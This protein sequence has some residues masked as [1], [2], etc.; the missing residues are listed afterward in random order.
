MSDDEKLLD[1][2]KRATA[3]LRDT[4]RRLRE[5]E[6]KEHEPIAVVGMSCRLPG[7]VKS[8]DDLWQLTADERDAISG[9]PANRGWHTDELDTATLQGGF[10]YDAPEFDADFFGISPREALAMD[11]QQRMLLETAWEAFEHAGID[12]TS[13]RATPVGV[14]TGVN[15]HGYASDVGELPE[16]VGGYLSTGVSGSVASGRVAYFMGLEGP[17]VTLDT[18]CSS[19]LVAVH[20]A[21]QALR[22]GDCTMALAGGVTVM[23]TPGA[24]VE[25][26]KQ[27][28]LSGDGRSKS[29]AAAADGTGWGEG[30]TT[31]LIEKLSDARKRGHQVL[32]VIRGTAVNQ[33]G[34]TNGLTAPSGK[35]QQRVIRAA[36]ADARLRPQ[37]VDAVEAHGTGT[38][39]G[40]PI[41]AQ[42]LL[43]TY[44]QDREV[45]LYLGSLKSNIGHT[46]AAAGAG[47]II[48]MVQALRYGVLPKSLHIDAPSPHI[49]W[50][51]GSVELLTEARAWPETGRPRR[52]GVS[53]FGMSGTNAHVVLEQAPAEEP[54]AEDTPAERP[55]GTLVP[56]TLSARTDAALRGQAE[57]LLAHLDRHPDA[58]PA[59]VARSLAAGRAHLEH[60][61][62]LIAADREEFALRLKE[63]AL[64]EPAPGVVRN[65]VT[66]DRSGP[67]FV[68]PGQGSQW[69]GMA[70]ELLDADPVFGARMAEC[71]R[72][73]SVHVDWS[74][75][76][77][78]RGEP[79]APGFDRVDVVQPV[80]FAVMVSLAALWRSYGVE[81]AAVVGHSQGE[82]A[83]A[84]VAG[85]LSLEDAAL[86]VALRSQAIREIA[87]HGGMMSVPQ[88]VAEVEERIAGYA[89]VSVAAVNGPRSTV[90]AGGALALDELLAAYEADGVRARRV[91]VDYASHSPHVEAIEERLAELLAPVRPLTPSVPF[92]TS[93]DGEIR[94]AFDAGYWYRNLR[95]TVRFERTLRELLADGHRRFVEIS[96]HPVLLPGVQETIETAGTHGAF[97]GETL[98]RH[99]GG[100][101]KFLSSVAEL[102]VRG[103]SV[104]WMAAAPTDGA[105][106]VPLPTY[107][108]QRQ[109]FWLESGIGSGD[110]AAAGLSAVG[111]PLAAA[112]VGLPGSGDLLFT[113]RLSLRSHP[114]AADR[115][116]HGVPAPG[117][118]V[119]AELA[120]GVG[121]RGGVPHLAELALHAPLLVPGQGAAQLRLVLSEGD[122]DGDGAR[123]FTVHSRAEDAPDG[124]DWTLH[125]TGTLT[126]AR[127]EAEQPAPPAVWPPRDAEPVD[128]ETVYGLLA[129][130][131]LGHGP[132]F[133]LL[134]EV[135]RHGD[136]LYAQTTLPDGQHDAD[137]GFALHPALLDAALQPLLADLADLAEDSDGLLLPSAWTAL[138]LHATGAKVLR[139]RVART[140]AHAAT[141]TSVD[142]AGHP[143]LTGTVHLAPVDPTAYVSRLPL[144]DALFG[145]E[146]HE[147]ESAEAV[148]EE[149]DGDW[150]VIG[151]PSLPSGGR[152]PDLTA[153]SDA[154][155]AGV[156]VPSY[157]RVDL[158]APGE[159]TATAVTGVRALLDAWSSDA[160]LSDSSLVL[161]SRGGERVVE[162]DEVPDLAV[163]AVRGLVRAW[164][165]AHPGRATLL[166][167]DGARDGA[168]DGATDGD[169]YGGDP[170]GVLAAAV[171]TGEPDL[172]LRAG[173]LRVRRLVRQ[174]AT[175]F[176][177]STGDLTAAGTILL[178][179]AAGDP[180]TAVL[181]HHLT[182][183]RG[184]R[185][186]T[187]AVPRH[188]V[189]ELQAEL[190]RLGADARVCAADLTDR[191]ATTELCASP[192]AGHPLTGVVH[193]AGG[194]THPDLAAELAAARH[195]DEAARSTDTAVFLL[196]P[197]AGDLLGAGQD[198][199][200]A[201]LAAHLDALAA[202]RRAAG[203][204]AAVLGWSPTAEAFG[205]LRPASPTEALRLLDATADTARTVAFVRPDP[206]AVREPGTAVPALLRSLVRPGARR[207]VN[208]AP[209]GSDALRA[210]LA[211]LTPAERES[212]LLPLVRATTA[213]VLGHASPDAVDPDRSFVELGIE[214]ITA[215]QLR[216]R[217]NEATALA[218][219]V[220]LVFDHPTATLLARHLAESLA[221]G[222]QV[223]GPQ[224][225]AT[226]G[227]LVRLFRQGCEL[228]RPTEA[229][230]L[231]TAAARL[232]P[233]FAMPEGISRRPSPVR[234]ARGTS[235]PAVYC[236]PSLSAISGPHEYLRFAAALQGVCDVTVLPHPGY[237]DG[238]QLPADRKALARA[239]AEAL[240]EESG[241]APVVLLGRSSGG[242]IAHQVAQELE[243]MGRPA[244][245]VI[246]LDTYSRS[247]DR[248]SLPLMTSQ[249]LVNADDLFVPLDDR[250]LTAMGRYIGIHSDWRPTAHDT[251][252]LLLRAA[253][254][255]PGV[256]AD[257]SAPEGGRPGWE[258]T[259]YRIEVPGDHFSMLDAHAATT[260][261][262]V[263]A[264]LGQTRP[265][266]DRA[267]APASA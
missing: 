240:L 171:A 176:T 152:Y 187:V 46:M 219:P 77:V 36:L 164:Q 102:Y 7:E 65:V 206:A 31:L 181:A 200:T 177:E 141:V 74:L 79:G 144:P 151:L 252:S 247:A 111:H 231:L 256:P 198:M 29:F 166:D 266:T 127:P 57:R 236:F 5:A 155:H 267:T 61:A 153:L 114:W 9:F 137:G 146:W 10:L 135:W 109:H 76:A 223:P 172:A 180:R 244:A 205:G 16:G 94:P 82:I 186:L 193:L 34:T 216:T 124:T 97:A 167:T 211:G 139:T 201:A 26:S 215:T 263:T 148:K 17:A 28:A 33:D 20:L 45:P 132:A 212:E 99:H 189:A 243:E 110:V 210:R 126:G 182:A 174:Q 48:K 191:S 195:L 59:A 220:T 50:T 250:R 40:D 154:L 1:Y 130:R 147:I 246:L 71:E 142:A 188:E 80:L 241:G 169:P 199:D 23:S 192:A 208:T 157:V 83:A 255:V 160:R 122:G 248:Y 103:G 184:A 56:W 234:L 257:T 90:I 196:I 165:Q 96:P 18:A 259:T 258:F 25:F 106:R 235:G 12:P 107:A 39:L 170:R 128:P 207:A 105:H 179:A 66:G 37:D 41:E 115:T 32:A 38:R 93:V 134:D 52:A 209:G 8:P 140:G 262:A 260:A 86:V 129:A 69:Q 84:C 143:V 251:P 138:T 98:R 131:G 230:Q 136:E 85:A 145:V 4:K 242:W 53:S 229:V 62:V 218:L 35:A 265:T 68:F 44:G 73:L 204:P 254:P 21:V 101:E 42:A 253:D 237:L 63:L 2:L 43:A 203:L 118:A 92:H 228:G 72:A 232:E 120:L 119:L 11:S 116:V 14:F 226:E 88:P 222:G 158:P 87:G 261:E 133:T 108:F 150:A 162:G 159:D 51:A 125:A 47:G 55:A 123:G 30:V 89:D 100:P 161:V 239:Q 249:M 22:R 91:P 238:E 190:D 163:A 3:D 173:D 202:R 213:A 168:R 64:G 49:D 185:H 24:F 75:G 183:V 117:D 78:L 264:W 104:D 214:S 112:A 54:A 19:S 149:G 217:L 121:E 6:E 178:T 70:V 27:G 113:G 81:P 225:A 13:V 67:V 194:G 221:D 95:N 156:A 227:T 58:E 197:G 175:E 15:Q 60:R 233:G 245:G 224:G